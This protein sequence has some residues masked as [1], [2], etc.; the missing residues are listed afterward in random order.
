MTTLLLLCL[1]LLQESSGFLNTPAFATSKATSLTTDGSPLLLLYA[2]IDDD[3]DDELL[4]M[5]A[6]AARRNNQ[7]VPEE[8]EEEPDFDGY[9]F[10][11]L[12]M[13]KWGECYDVDFNHVDAFGFREI[14]LNIYPF[15]MG[16]RNKWR[17]ASELDYLCHLQAIVEIL[18]KY[19]QLD[20]VIYQIQE[21][22]KKPKMG[23]PI[24]AVPLRLELTK[25]EIDKI[26]G[27]WS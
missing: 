22:S 4:D 13:A 24:K 11:D 10:R 20:H 12:L 3:D 23:A 9:A 7:Q 26:T 27:K 15:K 14:Y 19:E 8:K 5:A 18:E 1:G 21:T 16:G 25:D 6:F 2:V 17:H